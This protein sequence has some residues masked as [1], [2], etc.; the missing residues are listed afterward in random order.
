MRNKLSALFLLIL[1]LFSIILLV[2]YSLY[3]VKESKINIIEKEFLKEK[4]LSEHCSANIE[5][6]MSMLSKYLEHDVNKHSS[7]VKIESVVEEL[8][9]SL[10][11]NK[12]YLTSVTRMSYSGKIMSTVPENKMLEGSDIS[13]QQ[14][15]KRILNYHKP[16]FS[17]V[18]MAVQG[19]TAVAMHAPIF[20][21]GVFDGSIAYLV[22]IDDVIDFFKDKYKDSGR[23]DIHWVIGSNGRIIYSGI[24]SDAKKGFQD[25]FVKEHPVVNIFESFLESGKDKEFS[26]QNNGKKYRGYLKKIALPYGESWSIFSAIDE[27]DILG[28]N[29][30]FP[31]KSLVFIFLLFAIMLF[32]FFKLRVLGIIIKDSELLGRLQEN[33]Q[34]SNRLYKSVITDITSIICRL[35]SGKKIIFFNRVFFERFKSKSNRLKG[36]D[37]VELFSQDEAI[38][39][40]SKLDE[41][42]YDS[43]IINFE[44]S[45]SGTT[46][47][48]TYYI[49]SR[50]IFEGEELIEYQI[51]G[52]DISEY[53]HAAELES[54]YREKLKET[55]K[56][57]ALGALAAGVA[58]EFNNLLSGIQGSISLI[59]LRYG[60]NEDLIKLTSIME[61][62]IKKASEVSGRL[63]DLSMEG[64]YERSDI[65]IND[66]LIPLLSGLGRKYG[67]I[68]FI[69][70]LYSGSLKVRGDRSQIVQAISNILLNAVNSYSERGDVFIKTEL[71]EPGTDFLY[72]NSLKYRF[73]V[74]I[75][76]SDKGSGIDNSI[77]GMIFDPF[78]TTGKKGRGLGLPSAYGI[79]K[80]HGGTILFTS[81]KS[82]GSDFFVY[83]PSV[84]E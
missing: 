38:E 70:D 77:K 33:L 20:K 54:K 6:I 2:Y 29:I 31:V 60:K 43:Q 69:S 5:M 34:R 80:N 81:E 72:T 51:V 21:N 59:R 35:D 64:K 44:F 13:Y 10:E 27:N 62:Q 37:I 55:E 76:I 18:F 63:L 45:F 7:G 41:I 84:S 79:V 71:D 32:L 52:N 66:I 3:F 50:G 19:Y 83:L 22:S 4:F 65:E 30:Y 57:N 15:V 8:G 49:T 42:T 61:D 67:K 28:R 75:T 25:F 47:N 82:R 40:N 16:V 73:Y 56:I 24:K 68:N 11:L 9:T 46:K 12:P 78:F 36:K 14:H 1:V 26:F 58:H 39:L 23:N 17:D 74:K 53:K 48:L